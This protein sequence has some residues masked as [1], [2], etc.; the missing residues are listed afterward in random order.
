METKRRRDIGRE[1]SDEMAAKV[2]ALGLPSGISVR[3]A[4]VYDGHLSPRVEAEGFI[5][6]VIPIS[7]LLGISNGS[8]SPSVS[9]N[10]R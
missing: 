7:D 2:K 9:S 3:T 10:A 8:P 4:L 5:D 6:Y 1:I